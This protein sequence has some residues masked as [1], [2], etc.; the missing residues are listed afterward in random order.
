MTGSAIA[1]KTLCNM[2]K[3]DNILLIDVGCSKTY[4]ADHIPGS[5]WVPRSRISLAKEHNG[6][7]AS[8]VIISENLRRT[9]NTL[10]DARELWAGANV[11]RL[12][13]GS[14]AWIEA[15][16][17]TESG[18][19]GALCEADDVWYKPY[20]DTEADPAAMQAYFDWEYG[21]VDKVNRDGDA[22][23]QVVLMD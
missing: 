3:S 5:L 9:E 19:N 20:E 13:G 22:H 4:K 12:S 16:F 6:F 21:L 18:M 11:V 15:G 1:P 7:P 14:R 2:V 10:S 17:P 23:F 8:V